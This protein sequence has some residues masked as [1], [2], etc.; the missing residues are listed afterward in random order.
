MLLP[1]FVA[2][3]AGYAAEPAVPAATVAPAAAAVK[4]PAV[5]N[6]ECMDCH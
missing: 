6:S 2:A 1:L 4:K 5:A 3:V